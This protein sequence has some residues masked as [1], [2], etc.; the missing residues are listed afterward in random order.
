MKTVLAN[1]CFDPFHYG[2]LLHL[3]AAK[4]LGDV[5]VVSVTKDI[6]VNKGPGRPVFFEG[7]RAAVVGSLRCVDKVIRVHSSNEALRLIKPDIFVKGSEYEGRI[8]QDDL[9][10]CIQHNIQIVY[11][12]TDKYSSTAL[13]SHYESRRG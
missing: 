7:Q 4:R 5:L 12:R 9:E 8:S 11:T 6:A 1:G 10:Y 3:E 2:H 13:L